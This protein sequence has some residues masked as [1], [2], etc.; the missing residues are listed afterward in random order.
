MTRFHPRLL[1]LALA[2][3]ALLHGAG[4]TL[5]GTGSIRG[6]VTYQDKLVRS[7]SVMF[8]GSDSLPRYGPIDADG[9]YAVDRLPAGPIKITVTSPDPRGVAGRGPGRRPDLKDAGA[10]PGRSEEPPPAAV[11]AAW[12]A[13]PDSYGDLKTSKLVFDVRPGPNTFDIE[14]K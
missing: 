4:C 10:V 13:L 1:A 3:A 11:V 8:V 9:R 12:F 7:G 14:L 5:Q 6:K 2:A